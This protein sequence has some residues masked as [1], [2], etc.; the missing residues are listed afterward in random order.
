MEPVARAHDPLAADW[1]TGLFLLALIFIAAINRNAPR[2][3]RFLLREGL[4]I[5]QG[6]KA[7]RDELDLQDRN[8]LGIVL[9]AIASIALFAWQS[10]HVEQVED[11]PSYLSLIGILTLVLVALWSIVRLSGVLAGSHA[12]TREHARAG[13]IILAM[14]GLA[15]FP[16]VVLMAFQAAWREELVRVGY[17]LVTAALLYRWVRGIGV[18]MVEG[19]PIRYI[20]LYFCAAEA[21]PLLLAIHALRPPI[22]PTLNL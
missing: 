3:W 18:G 10:L 9:L 11:A 22:H 5:R 8:Y 20:I 21:M 7:L 13:S 12:A 6:P 14:L 1:V 19:V 15:L 16:L 4:R 2:K 17:V